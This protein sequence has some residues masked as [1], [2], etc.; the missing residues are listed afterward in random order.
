MPIQAQEADSH[1]VQEESTV[2]HL[3]QVHEAHLDTEVAGSTRRAHRQVDLTSRLIRQGPG[4]TAGGISRG[5]APSQAWK[6]GSR[7]ILAA[8]SDQDQRRGQT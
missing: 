6:P 1:G 2:G 5:T 7:R 4:P 8:R 3:A